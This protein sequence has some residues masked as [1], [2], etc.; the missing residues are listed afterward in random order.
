MHTHVP[1][2]LIWSRERLPAC[3]MCTQIR[4]NAGVRPQ[5]HF[6]SQI[7]HRIW[8]G[9]WEHGHVWRDLMILKSIYYE[10]TD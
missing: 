7:S 10:G 6:I 2:K 4:T 9:G 8:K 3:G 5:L 1:G